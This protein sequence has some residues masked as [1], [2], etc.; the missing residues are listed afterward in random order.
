MLFVT[1]NLT[2]FHWRKRSLHTRNSHFQRAKRVFLIWAFPQ[3]PP[4]LGNAWFDWISQKE[5]KATHDK[6]PF[7]TRETRFPKTPKDAQTENFETFFWKLAKLTEEVAGDRVGYR[8]THKIKT[9]KPYISLFKILL[10]L[11]MIVWLKF[12]NLWKWTTLALG[13]PTRK[14]SIRKWRAGRRFRAPGVLGSLGLPRRFAPWAPLRGA[15]SGKKK[16]LKIFN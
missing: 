10:I 15:A 1:Q 2:E 3:I 7:S 14:F 11:V 12:L 13:D 8:K 9:L 6:R 4:P 16:C 5:T